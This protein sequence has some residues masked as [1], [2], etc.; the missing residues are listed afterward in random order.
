M[1]RALALTL[2]GLS[3]A[4]SLRAEECTG[5]P[6]VCGRTEFEAG[7]AA[8]KSGDFQSARD[9]FEAAYGYRAHPVV[10]FNLA[11]AESRLGHSL[12]ALS[13][14]DQVLA[15]PQLP[16]DLKPRVEDER[17]RA[18]QAVATIEIDAGSGAEAL[19]DDAKVS[20]SPAVARVD[21]GTHRVRVMDQGRT[22]LDRS[23]RVRAGER[24]RLAVDRSR[25]VVVEPGRNPEKDTGGSRAGP[26]PV[27]FYAGLGLTAVLGGVTIWSGLDTQSAFDKYETDLPTL[28]QAEADQRVEDGHKKETRTNVLI[29]A[30]SLAAVGTAALAVFVVDWGGGNKKPT[31]GLA[32]GPGSIQ[33]FG[34][35]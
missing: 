34:R 16:K 7:V 10:L 26:S 25:E 30:T 29:A 32:V 8:F 3:V 33:A 27:W 17:A 28:T 31:T 20:G 15:D 12:K 35:F 13:Q 4:P 9:H 22:V 5:E 1:R 14:L 6:A 24:L 19:V 11:L 21:A 23:V 2:V 18:D